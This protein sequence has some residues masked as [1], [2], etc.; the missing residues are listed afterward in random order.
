MATG[1]DLLRALHE[2]PEDMAVFLDPT[3]IEGNG[4]EGMKDE[5]FK[6]LR[7]GLVRVL[8]E[9]SV[10]RFRRPSNTFRFMEPTRLV[11]FCSHV[12]QRRHEPSAV[13]L[14][15]RAESPLDSQNYSST[16]IR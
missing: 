1:R 8:A 9:S 13:F 10:S 2:A 4:Q 12:C 5:R 7:E 15:V 14:F 3:I 6:P 11:L 16:V